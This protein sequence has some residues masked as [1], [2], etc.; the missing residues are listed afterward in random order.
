[1][2]KYLIDHVK[3]FREEGQKNVRIKV[4]KVVKNGNAGQVIVLY[5]PPCK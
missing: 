2:T 3:Q 4:G 5:Q 1:L